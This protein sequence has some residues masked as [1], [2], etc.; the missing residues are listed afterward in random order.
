MQTFLPHPEFWRSAR[1]LDTR[2]LGKQ[3]VEALQILLALSDETAGWQRHPAVLQ[4]RDH[5]AVL[6]SYG[7]TMCIEWLNRGYR[8]TCRPK[9]QQYFAL[10]QETENLTPWWLGHELYHKSHRAALLHKN[11]AHYSQFNWTEE[12]K[13][14]YFWP[15]KQEKR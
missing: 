14:D 3:R 4:W 12:P 13:L 8:D 1:V 9:L 15:S 7:E 10:Y 6:A 5:R 2:R 11:P